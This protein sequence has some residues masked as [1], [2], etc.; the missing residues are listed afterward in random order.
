[1]KV[2]RT[3]TQYPADGW[4]TARSGGA[5]Y[6][7]LQVA[8]LERDASTRT[9]HPTQIGGSAAPGAAGASAPGARADA[10]APHAPQNFASVAIGAEH[11]EQGR[12]QR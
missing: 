8:Q 10:F 9:P 3:A 12:I 1:V 6:A 2:A 7:A 11:W 5:V 4:A